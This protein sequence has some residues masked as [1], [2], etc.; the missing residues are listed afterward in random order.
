MAA[1]RSIPV[2]EAWVATWIE[3]D[4]SDDIPPGQRPAYHL[5]GEFRVE[6]PVE[7]AHLFATAHGVY[8]AFL[9]GTRVGDHE[10]TPGFTA[11]HTRLQVQIFDVTDLLRPGPNA[12]GA[13]LSD[14]W[15]RGQHGIVRALDAYGSTTAWLAELHV[16]PTGG[17]TMV[18][19][20]DGS[21]RSTPSHVLGADLIA[22][23]VHDLRRR[24]PGWA[25]PGHRPQ[26]LGD[27]P[28]GGPRRRRR[29][30]RPS[31][32]RRGAS[33]SCPPSRSPSSRRV[34]TSSTSV[35]TATAGSVSTTSAR[36]HELTVIHGEWLD[37]EGDV[38]LDNVEHAAFAEARD[39][40]LPFQTDV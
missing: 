17:Q 28:D 9:N 6:S 37:A 18:F 38:T 20:T 36:R 30:A 12:L 26:R 35:R 10:L 13:L 2:P 11:Y 34:A 25:E 3:P 29:C 39:F 40:V 4:E 33:R 15:W 21:W 24:V 1:V 14:G 5:A 8:E 31:A 32:R 19:G 7:S 16:T 27:R 23:E 22:G